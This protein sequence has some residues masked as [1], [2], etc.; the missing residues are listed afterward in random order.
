MSTPAPKPRRR[1]PRRLALVLLIVL[2]TPLLVIGFG[3]WQEGRAWRVACAEADTLDP[4]WRWDELVASRPSVPDGEN[5]ALTIQ[6]ASGLL[7]KR[8]HDWSALIR[9]DDLTPPPPADPDD[10]PPDPV[11]AADRR[12]TYGYLLEG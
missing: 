6:A 1:W 11:P 10:P 5:S 2:G 9:D 4:G 7:P 8:W 12:R 3:R